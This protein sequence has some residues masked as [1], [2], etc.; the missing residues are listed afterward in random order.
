[1][2]KFCFLLLLVTGIA[3]ADYWTYPTKDGGEIVLTT[4]LF[5]PDHS[6]KNCRNWYAGYVIDKFNR[7][8]YGCW[9]VS[10]DKI[11]AYFVDGDFRVYDKN[12]WIYHKD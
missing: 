7:V 4:E 5:P 2:K 8:V 3:H 9:N 6:V 12:N 11:H 10:N 1:M